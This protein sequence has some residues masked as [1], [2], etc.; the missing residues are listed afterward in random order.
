MSR[1]KNW[2]GRPTRR[3]GQSHVA[4][5]PGPYVSIYCSGRD[6][7]PHTKHMITSFVPS[8]QPG[9]T[10]WVENP[11]G[12]AAHGSARYFKVMP[13][14][15]QW[16]EGDAWLPQDEREDSRDR[17]G[18]RSRWSLRCPTCSLSKTYARPVELGDAISALA[19]LRSED[20]IFEVSLRAFIG[21]LDGWRNSA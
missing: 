7:S 4:L 8:D 12:Y 6:D 9:S 13:R 2:N 15:T 11:L 16:L 3:A 10:N 17:A 5:E 19:L 18:F 14:I 21:H 20:G 1:K